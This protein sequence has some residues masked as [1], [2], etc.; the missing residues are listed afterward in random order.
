MCLNFFPCKFNYITYWILFC[1]NSTKTAHNR[2]VYTSNRHS[3][4]L[5]CGQFWEPLNSLIKKTYVFF[6]KER[7]FFC[8]NF[9]LKF[10]FEAWLRP[11][12]LD[13]SACS[14]T[15][16]ILNIVPLVLLCVVLLSYLLCELPL[17]ISGTHWVSK[18]SD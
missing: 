1:F 4:D 12:P 16:F 8:H 9:C 14:P 11:A 18:N 13:F 7:S 5:S 15:K 10:E 2:K 6:L 3:I 17:S